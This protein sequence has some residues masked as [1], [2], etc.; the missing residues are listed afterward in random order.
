MEWMLFVVE[1]LQDHLE[2]GMQRV[3][4]ESG[5]NMS[6]QSLFTF[7]ATRLRQLNIFTTQLMIIDGKGRR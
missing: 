3:D 7:D 5:S 2:C 6:Y 4:G 1:R